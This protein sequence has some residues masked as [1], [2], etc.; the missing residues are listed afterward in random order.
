MSEDRILQLIRLSKERSPIARFLGIGLSFTDNLESVVSLEYNPNLDNVAGHIHGGIYATL[1]D[2]AGWFACAV[3]HDDTCWI[4]T[5]HITVHFLEAVKE[6][7]LRAVG[8]VIKTGK[9]QDVAEM[10]LYDAGGNLVGH[11]SGTFVILRDLVLP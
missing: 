5:S 9:R 3:A 8:R 2:M 1:L 4:A 7:S 11:A 6:T 10:N